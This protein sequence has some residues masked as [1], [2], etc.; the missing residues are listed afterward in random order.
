MPRQESPMKRRPDGRGAANETV[1]G[2]NPVRELI[3]SCPER[4]DRVIVCGN[5]RKSCSDIAAAAEKARVRVEFEDQASFSRRLPGVSHQGVCAIIEAA[6]V[7]GLAEL[8]EDV[9]D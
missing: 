2:K 4:I 1:Y 6:R 7:L 8:A 5:S 3:S 9:E